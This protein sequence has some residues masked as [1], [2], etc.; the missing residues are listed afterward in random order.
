MILFDPPEDISGVASDIRIMQGGLLI[1]LDP[2]SLMI[3][4]KKKAK[5][6]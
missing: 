1:S 6:I 3:A 2:H 5:A 4:W